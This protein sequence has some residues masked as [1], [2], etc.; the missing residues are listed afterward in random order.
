MA[1]TKIFYV[2]CT[3]VILNLYV[4]KCLVLVVEIL[5]TRLRNL[6]QWYI[7]RVCK[8]NIEIT[9]RLPCISVLGWIIVFGTQRLYYK[10]YIYT[11]YYLYCFIDSVNGILPFLKKNVV[12][13]W[14]RF[15]SLYDTLYL[16]FIINSDG[17]S[18]WQSLVLV[19]I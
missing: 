11:L 8:C 17:K 19:K 12:R 7:H 1:T 13:V 6:V 9:H 14:S 16:F 2:S 3:D 15:S 18:V 10:G 5:T 4:V